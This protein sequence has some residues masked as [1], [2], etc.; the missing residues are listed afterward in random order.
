[1][2]ERIILHAGTP[3]TGT[4]SL[5]IVLERHRDELA[6]RGLF[7]P[8]TMAT[9]YAGGEGIKP[10][11]QWLVDD[12]TAVDAGVLRRHVDAALAEAPACAQTIVFST[13]GLFN[14]WWDFSQA[15]RTELSVLAREYV[16][17]LWVWF[18]APIG[19]FVSLYIQALKNPHA[20]IA[21]Y[22]QDWS[23]EEMLDDPWFARHLNYMRFVEE[24]TETLGEG[25]VRPYA[26]RGTTVADFFAAAGLPDF[27]APEPKEHATLGKFGVEVLRLLNRLTSSS[28][29]KMECVNLINRLDA[30][31]GASWRPFQLKAPVSARILSL[32]A[33]SVEWLKRKYAV[34]LTD[35]E[36]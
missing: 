14:H 9:R 31:L 32:S 22:G 19:F 13:E 8:K 6:S 4:T 21:C 26:Y 20:P 23:P 35:A 11:H 34:D 30:E 1:M 7:Y 3:K 5:Q 16:V 17:E 24:V 25:A 36:Q 33:P 2:V 18:R 12:L 15:G 27:T 10:K 29:A 28:E